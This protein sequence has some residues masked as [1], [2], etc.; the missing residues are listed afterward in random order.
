MTSFVMKLF[1]LLLVGAILTPGAA[2]AGNNN[3]GNGCRNRCGDTQVNNNGDRVVNNTTNN[4]ASASAQGGA[5]SN[6]SS[7]TDPPY[8][9]GLFVL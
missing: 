6:D 9:E 1:P 8:K 5:E 4:N 2:L 3:N 7:F